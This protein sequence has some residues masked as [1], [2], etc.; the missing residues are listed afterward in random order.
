[1]FDCRVTH[2]HTLRIDFIL[3]RPSNISK[4]QCVSKWFFFNLLQEKKHG[5]YFGGILHIC[6]LVH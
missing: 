4:F 5:N 1:M 6:K 2:T 3:G